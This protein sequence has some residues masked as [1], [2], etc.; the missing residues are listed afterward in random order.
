MFKKILKF[1]GIL[2]ATAAV[3]F[4]TMVPIDWV[5]NHLPLHLTENQILDYSGT[6]GVGGGALFIALISY[7]RGWCKDLKEGRFKFD[8]RVIPI[9]LFVVT[10]VQVILNSVLG[11]AFHKIHPLVPEVNPD[12]ESTLMDYI[13]SI[14][15]APLTEEFMFR[16]GIYGAMRHSFNKTL[17][18]IATA[19]MFMLVHGFQ[20][21]ASVLC[22][23]VGFIL[24]YVFEKTGNIWYSISVHSALNAYV[25]IANYLVRKGVPFYSGING[26]IVYHVVVIAAAA[27]IALLSAYVISKRGRKERV[28]SPCS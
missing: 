22:L 24:A 27:G 10:A 12:T 9:C 13:F 18:M 6:L 26:Y 15:L 3:A 11:L 20:F 4:A 14:V 1:V 8:Q 16:F 17:S 2:I 25:S 23:V 28:Q 21:Q 5:M 19:V 7:K